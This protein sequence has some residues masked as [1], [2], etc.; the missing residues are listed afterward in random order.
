MIEEVLSSSIAAVFFTAFIISALMWYACLSTALELF[1]P[2]RYQWDN[3]YFCVDIER[4]VKSVNSIFLNKA[5]IAM[6]IGKKYQ[7]N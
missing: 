7:I 2:S 1:G 3:G 6:N 5:T 4:R